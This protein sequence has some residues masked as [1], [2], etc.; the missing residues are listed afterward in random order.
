MVL[1]SDYLG[2]YFWCPKCGVETTPRLTLA[3]ADEDV[4][5]VPVAAP[6]TK[7]LLANG[8]KRLD[9]S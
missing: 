8:E 6:H 1:C 7:S 4:V 2:I 3:E 9:E 5:W